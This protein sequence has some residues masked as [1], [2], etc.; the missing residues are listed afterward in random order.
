MQSSFQETEDLR[1]G[2]ECAERVQDDHKAEE[3]GVPAAVRG[4]TP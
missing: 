1:Q 3:D 4:E 2:K